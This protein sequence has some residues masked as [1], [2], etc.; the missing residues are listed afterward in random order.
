MGGMNSGRRFRA[1]AKDKVGAYCKI[2]VR[3]LQRNGYLE[4]GKRSPLSWDFNGEPAGSIGM[5]AFNSQIMLSYRG[6]Q[7]GGEWQD[8]NYTVQLTYTA[9]NYGRSRPWFLCPAQGCGR[10]V[11]ILY[12]GTIYVCRHCHRLAYDSQSEN[13]TYRALRRGDKI[14]ARL[15]PDARW[16]DIPDRPK[17][18]H[19]QTYDRLIDAAV[20]A[21][22]ASLAWLMG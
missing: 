20:A 21:D 17:G 14:R 2:D 6:R 19:R 3:R 8:Y 22:R 11:A 10:R 5:V 7:N 15:D 16:R 9:C 12:G 1:F 18:M 4:P 13:F